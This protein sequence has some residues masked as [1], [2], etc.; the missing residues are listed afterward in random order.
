MKTIEI[1][2]TEWETVLDFYHAILKA[3][4]APKGHGISID[5]LL[6]SMIWGGMNSVNAPYIIRVKNIRERPKA[7]LLEI[8]LLA[9]CISKARADFAARHGHAPDVRLELAS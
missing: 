3:I 8:E 7:I 5:A 1:D 9:R 4:G 6:D 2:A